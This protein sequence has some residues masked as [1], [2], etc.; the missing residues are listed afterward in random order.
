[1]TPK[2]DFKRVLQKGVD[3]GTDIR[4]VKRAISRHG[5][6][7]WTQFDNIWHT[8]KGSFSQVGLKN[9]QKHKGL[10]VDGIY[11]EKTHAALLKSRVPADH[12]HAGEWC[13]DQTSINLYNGY[14]DYS[15]AEKIV[16]A[17]F[18]WWRCAE[19]VAGSWH[20]SQWRPFDFDAKCDAGGRSDCS[21]M[22]IQAAHGA[23]AKSPDI[24][25][26]YS[27]Y[28]NTDSLRRGGIPIS[29]SDVIRYC[30]DHYVLAFYGPS[31]SETD[32]V[33]AGEAPNIWHSN[34]NENAPEIWNGV[35]DTRLNFLGCRSYQ[36]I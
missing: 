34:G 12:V 32:H 20:Y 17:I 29:T 33:I 9:F 21:G 2:V 23:G 18:K 15:A 4:A 1:M 22:T 16:K 35:Y 30:K 13:F 24:V 25:C 27:G 36:V 8:G 5:E 7:P 11:G 3:P 6:W 19:G 14:Q 26:G 10:E 31:W 28:G